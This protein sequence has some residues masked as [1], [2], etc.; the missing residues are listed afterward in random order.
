MKP[1][2][3][4]KIDIFILVRLNSTRLPKKQLKKI[5]NKPILKIL[6]NRLKKSKNIRNIIIC[7]TN[8]KT[9]DPLVNFLK[10]EKILYY[11]G[12]EKDVLKRMLEAA[13]KFCTD[14]I[15][16][17]EGDKIYTD[18]KLVDLVIKQFLNSKNEFVIGSR[19]KKDFDPTDHFIHG[20]C[21]AGFR[22]S[23]LE[24]ICDKKKTNNTETG[25]KELFF[26]K[27][28]CSRTFVTIPR[29]NTI[30][31][32]IRLTLDYPEDLKLAKKI[33]GELG[34]DF[35]YKDILKLYNKNPEIFKISKKIS[36]KWKINYQ[37]SRVKKGFMPKK[38]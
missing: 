38:S 35:G 10:K 22:T 26:E 6:V 24:K 14:I 1:N 5:D 37:K 31:K 9:D 28:V 30:P 12:S 13:K 15:I 7:T 25:Y 27:G 17:V 11:R 20:V 3:I 16:D 19:N 2:D 4:K 18:V 29:N 33:F 21:P 36:D 34:N 8:K 32:E 23:V